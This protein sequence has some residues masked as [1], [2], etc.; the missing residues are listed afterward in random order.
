[1]RTK[2]EIE[3]RIRKIR[4]E[5]KYWEKMKL[6]YKWTDYTRENGSTTYGSYQEKASACKEKIELLKWVLS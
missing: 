4:E 3:A 5:E 6:D 2:D 1:M